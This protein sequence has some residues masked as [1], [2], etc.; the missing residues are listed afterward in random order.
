MKNKM[1]KLGQQVGEKFDLQKEEIFLF[2]I[3]KMS[4]NDK[5]FY[6]NEVLRKV[7]LGFP[8]SLLINDKNKEIIVNEFINGFRSVDKEL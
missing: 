4:I 7:G 3:E 5:I 8:T 6:I 2:N 1:F